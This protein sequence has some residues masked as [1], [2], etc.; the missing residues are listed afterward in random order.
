MST[1]GRS[2]S[3]TLIYLLGVAFV[4][5]AG[6]LTTV[7]SGANAQLTRTLREI[8]WPAAVFGGVAFAVLLACALASR[9]PLP[10]R[11]TLAAAPWWAWIGGAIAAFYG[12]ATVTMPDRLGAAIFTG[13]AV[14]AAVVCSVLLDHFG[15]VGFKSHPLGIGRIVGVVLMVAG[16]GCVAAF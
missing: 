10:D 2:G 3:A 15:L 5:V 16:L 9:A 11:A 4:L 14:T 6:A 12:L 7:E 8:W 1:D 13:L